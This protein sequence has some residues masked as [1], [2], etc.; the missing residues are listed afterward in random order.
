MK[1][2]AA[3][4]L[5]LCVVALQGYAQ[6]QNVYF[7]KNN[8][9]YVDVRDSADYIRIVREPDSASVLYNVLEFYLNGNKKLIGKSSTIDPP[10]FE[11]LCAA[12]YP[13]GK[14]QSV[15]N[16]KNGVRYGE[17]I[18]FYP[19]GKPY[20]EVTYQGS[21]EPDNDFN[22]RYLIKANNDSLGNALVTDGNGYYKGYNSKFTYFEEEGP[23]KNG[24][25]DSIWKGE[26][27]VLHIKFTETYADGKLLTGTANYPDSTS[28]TYTGSRGVPPQFKGGYEGFGKF[29]SNNI[30]YPDYARERGIQGKV[31]LSFVVEKTGDLSDIK[32][33]K[34][35][36]P[37]IDA[38]AV[39][40]LKKSPK[41]LP[42]K[43][44]GKPVRVIYNV[45]VNF[46]L[47]N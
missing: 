20:L 16:Y 12:Y 44:F 23:V 46:A 14:R 5:F 6:K 15:I 18:S 29:L 26:F 39:R 36:S 34:S 25:R 33:K 7:L 13:N 45:P 28:A 32:V 4:I 8:G 1:K 11:G 31:I 24:R 42:G 37:G 3:A 21:D 22:N 10:K 2:F 27:K 38:E 35:V 19:N 40:V 47:S 43:Q 41:W 17:D 30:N 9:K